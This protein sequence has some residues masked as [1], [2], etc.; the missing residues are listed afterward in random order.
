MALARGEGTPDGT[1]A[2][3]VAELAGSLSTDEAL[4]LL[5]GALRTRRLATAR[6]CL[7]ALAR[8]RGPGVIRT[9][10]NVLAVERPELAVAAADAL[11][12][13]DASAEPALV[14]ALGATDASVRAAAARALGRMG[15]TAAVQSLRSLEERD[16]WCRAA[17]RQAIAVIQ[18]RVAGGGPGQLSLAGAESGQL[19]L[20]GNEEGRLSL[21]GRESGQLPLAGNEAGP[22]SLAADPSR[23]GRRWSPRM[24]GD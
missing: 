6:E 17:A 16:R 15:T 19:S 23:P 21:V 10:S 22:G 24:T 3:A 20:A 2:R 13:G 9:L 11:G 14:S 4:A 1:T 8:H 12:A 18:S 7:G 5:R